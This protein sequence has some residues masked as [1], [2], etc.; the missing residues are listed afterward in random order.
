MRNLE[1]KREEVTRDWRRL[2]NEQLRN[3]YTS[4]NIIRVIISRRMRSV[5]HAAQTGEMEMHAIFWLEYLK[6]RDH[7]EVLGKDGKM[8]L[9]LV[10]GKLG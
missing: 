5:G 6:G 7:S 9:E 2:Y 1:P 4:P 3:M 8:I 10:S